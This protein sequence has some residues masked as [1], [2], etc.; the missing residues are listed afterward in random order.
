MMRNNHN[1]ALI[2]KCILSLFL[3]IALN[4]KTLYKCMK[5]ISIHQHHDMYRYHKAVD[6]YLD[7]ISNAK[8]VYFPI[9]GDWNEVFSDGSYDT[10]YN[11]TE[12]C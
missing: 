11:E 1:F 12:R 8:I 7:S 6:L 10:K 9:E 2:K 3:L 4:N 5:N